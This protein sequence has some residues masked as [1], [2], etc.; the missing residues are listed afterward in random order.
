MIYDAVENKSITKN[1]N[2]I[3]GNNP[4]VKLIPFNIEMNDLCDNSV[5]F[6]QYKVSKQ[7]EKYLIESCK[8]M[9]ELDFKN[10]FDF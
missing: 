7:L 9:Y 2:E 3:D 8:L 1:F 10:K 6:M 5:L 4:R